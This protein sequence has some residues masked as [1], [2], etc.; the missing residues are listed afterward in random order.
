MD[1]DQGRAAAGHD[2]DGELLQTLQIHGLLGPDYPA[3][4]G[5][6]RPA[7]HRILAAAAAEKGVSVRTGTTV[8]TLE[9][10]PDRVDVELS[11]GASETFDLVLAA[12]GLRS[13]IRELVFGADAPV[14]AAVGQ[15][16]WRALSHRPAKVTGEYEF[17]GP[18][19]K[20]GFT[21]LA[22]DKMYQ[23]L[24]QPVRTRC[25]RRRRSGRAG[26][27]SC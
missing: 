12:D 2:V 26:C 9:Q 4:G 1:S 17:Y 14:P 19:L 13:Q 11:D 15:A 10:H 8:T 23:F 22:P 3:V 27:A 6:L 18:G 7:L 25:C 21:P 20:T 5:M 24:V 16:V